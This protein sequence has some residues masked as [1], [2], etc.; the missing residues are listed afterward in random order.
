MVESGVLLEM[1][2]ATPCGSKRFVRVPVP[3]SDVYLTIGMVPRFT[4]PA[5]LRLLV[6]LIV[7]APQ[8]TN[9]MVGVLPVRPTPSV[10]PGVAAL[11]DN[12]R[13]LSV[14]VAVPTWL[15]V[16]TAALLTVAF[17]VMVDSV[18]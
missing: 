10:A 13:L 1:Y 8:F 15:I 4:A 17:P 11:P 12:V 9:G 16:R 14:F 5:T 7:S 3:A 18:I 6:P 2:P